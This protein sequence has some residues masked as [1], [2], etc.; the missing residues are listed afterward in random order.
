MFESRPRFQPSGFSGAFVTNGHQIIQDT[1]KVNQILGRFKRQN[2]VKLPEPKLA[3]QS[4]LYFSPEEIGDDSGARC[5]TCSMRLKGGV[6]KCS[7]VSDP[8]INLDHGV[9]GLFLFGPAMD[10]KS[11]EMVSKDGAG[12]IDIG[13]PTHCGNCEYFLVDDDDDLVGACAKVEGPVEFH[14]CCNLWESSEK[15]EEHGGHGD[16]ESED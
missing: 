15:E 11:H 2:P 3:K 13:A 1:M 12:Y 6:P 16:D 8:L 14:G 9:S 10:T 5:G 4:A 7:V